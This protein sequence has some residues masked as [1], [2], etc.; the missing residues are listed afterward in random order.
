[1]AGGDLI[2]RFPVE[3]PSGARRSRAAR[4]TDDAAEPAKA[5]HMHATDDFAPAHPDSAPTPQHP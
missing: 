4:S 3:R 2:E 1:V 5:D